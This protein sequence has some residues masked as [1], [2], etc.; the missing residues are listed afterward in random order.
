MGTRH[1]N[2]EGLP[3]LEPD[4]NRPL[5]HVDLLSNA[6]SNPSGRGGILVEF[7]LQGVQLLLRRPLP[8][9]VLLLLSKCAL[10]GWSS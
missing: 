8:L 10:A 9:L 3:V 5:G 1:N 2:Q 6:F 7:H 4:L